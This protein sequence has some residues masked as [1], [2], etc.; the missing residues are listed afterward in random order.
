MARRITHALALVSLLSAGG[1]FASACTEDGSQLFIG[2]ALIPD[3]ESC[4]VKADPEGP[5][6][7]SKR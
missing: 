1:L 3:A 7:G 6:F 4:S 2:G 5:F